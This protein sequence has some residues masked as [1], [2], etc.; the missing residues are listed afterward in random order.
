MNKLQFVMHPSMREHA[1]SLIHTEDVRGI[2]AHTRLMLLNAEITYVQDIRYVQGPALGLFAQYPAR[3]MQ[4]LA[5]GE[6]RA[7]C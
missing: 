4:A 1:E 7:P 6:G 2:H 3:T 5:N